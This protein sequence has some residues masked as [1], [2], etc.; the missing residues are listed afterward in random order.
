MD[1]GLLYFF[2]GQAVVILLGLFASHAKLSEKIAEIRGMGIQLQ[3]TTSGLREDHIRLAEQ[4]EGI[5]RHVAHIE[6]ME[7]ARNSILKSR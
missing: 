2:I 5:S 6:G 4:V 1:E 7:E 3:I